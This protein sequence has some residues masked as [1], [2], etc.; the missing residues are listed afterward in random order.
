MIKRIIFDI[1]N[2][3]LD[4]YKDCIDTYKKYI[5]YNKLNINAK[6][7]YDIFEEYEVSNGNYIKEDLSIFLS[8]KIKVDKIDINNLL[9]LYSNHSTLINNNTINILEYLSKKYE[10]VALTNWYKDIQ[11]KRLEKVGI[12]NYFKEIYGIEDAKKPNP[13]AFKK[14]IGNNLYNECVMIGDSLK[15]DIEVPK[16]LG[17]KTIYYNK[18]CKNNNENEINNLNE[19]LNILKKEGIL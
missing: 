5:E 4:T 12:N 13:E 18:N 11:Y 16:E 17:M 1:D 19:L 6:D 14:A 2:T 3:L 10:I 9:D 7:I 8:K 15:S